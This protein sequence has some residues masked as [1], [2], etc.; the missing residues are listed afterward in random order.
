MYH[1]W[2]NNQEEIYRFFEYPSY[3]ENKSIG[4]FY[5][6]DPSHKLEAIILHELAHALQFTHYRKYNCRCSPHGPL[7]K[8][9]YLQLRQEF[10]NSKLPEQLPLKLDYEGYKQ[11]L[12]LKV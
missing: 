5:S 7:F 3:D 12:M 10:L 1:A 8:Q 2:P 11:T 4:G 6:K 9:Y